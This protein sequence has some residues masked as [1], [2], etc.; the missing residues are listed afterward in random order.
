VVYD[1][2]GRS[3]L[4]D[5]EA[6]E[7]ATGR[8]RTKCSRMRRERGACRPSPEPGT[9]LRAWGRRPLY[10]SRARVRPHTGTASAKNRRPR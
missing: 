10:S 7:L 6:T 9:A 1:R 3:L 2:A 4:D 8:P 5:N